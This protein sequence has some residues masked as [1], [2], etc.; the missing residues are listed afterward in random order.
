M[1][2]RGKSRTPLAERIYHTLFSRI[3]NGDYPAHSK[4]P[5][6]T[7]LAQE[8]GISR[9]VLRSA[10][11]RLREEGLLYSRQGAGSFVKATAPGALGFAPV[12]SLADVQRCL[13]FR[14]TLEIETA[15]LAASRRNS[16]ALDEMET[17]ISAL[18]TDRPNNERR[19]EFDFNFHLAIAKATNNHFFKASLVALREH[20]YAAIRTHNRA[21]MTDEASTLD[22][23]VA[24]HTA[25]LQAIR[26]AD[27]QSAAE[28]MRFH[29]ARGRERLFG[30][31]LLDLRQE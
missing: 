23:V 22:E 8:L 30:G 17:A 9:P 28:A 13:E 2:A 18:E 5:P 3:S 14:E 19:E 10:L 27:P 15:G 29:L 6:E 20:I 25:I 4:L 24:D 26:A 7:K 11:D 21:L 31:R 12:E 1:A 16:A